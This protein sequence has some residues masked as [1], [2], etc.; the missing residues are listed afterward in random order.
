MGKLKYRLLR[1]IKIE[2]CIGK[3]EQEKTVRIKPDKATR[4]DD[5]ITIFVNQESSLHS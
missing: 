3:K 1:F 5:E 4:E 2:G